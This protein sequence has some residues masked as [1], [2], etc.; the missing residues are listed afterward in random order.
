MF[1]TTSP[2]SF[3]T[4]L[5]SPHRAYEQDSWK[6]TEKSTADV[7]VPGFFPD[8]EIVRGDMLDY[9]VEIEWF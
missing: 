6:R 8:D 9:A 5:M 7:K 1:V 3:G 2:F 4:A